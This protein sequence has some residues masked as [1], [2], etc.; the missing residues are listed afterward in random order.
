MIATLYISKEGLNYNKLETIIASH[1][2]FGD[3]DCTLYKSRSFTAWH[4]EDSVKIEFFNI[5]QE[6]LRKI[7]IAFREF[8]W[9]NCA[10]LD[11]EKS[12]CNEWYFGCIVNS[13][14]I[15]KED[16]LRCSDT[17]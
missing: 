14:L 12:E 4:F 15:K 3:V 7:Y 6:V 1:S 10:V 9:I 13:P 8:M 2:R 17:I 11:I 5:P 16:W